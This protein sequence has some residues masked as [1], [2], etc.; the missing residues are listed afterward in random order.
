METSRAGVF[1]CGNVVHI[2]DLVDFVSAEAAL[3]GTYAGQYACGHPPPPDNL[4]LQA[5]ENVAYCVPQTVATDGEHTV[6][7]RVRRS[8]EACTLRLVDVGGTFVY[9][10]KLRYVVPAEMVNLTLEPKLLAR[11]D[12]AAIR[13][14][15]VPRP[16]RSAKEEES[17][18]SASVFTSTYLCIG[19][20]LGCRLEVDEDSAAHSGAHRARVWLPPRA[21]VCDPGAYGA[22]ADR[23]DYGGHQ[24]RAVAAAARAQQPAGAQGAR[25]RHLPAAG[26]R[27]GPGARGVGAGDRRRRGGRGD[28]SRVRYCGHA[29]DGGG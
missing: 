22:A 4:R 24:R 18:M 11:F 17:A 26:G 20:P 5:G 14:D 19:C 27:A 6:Y 8:L 12:G 21:G 29:G 10:K 25:V 7:L 3:A 16:V 2:H 9:E 23:H 15:V 13:I 1:A 28:G